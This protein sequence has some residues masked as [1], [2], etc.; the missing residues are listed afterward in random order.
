[1]RLLNGEFLRDFFVFHLRFQ[2]DDD[3]AREAFERH[4]AVVLHLR[5]QAGEGFLV[6]T[7]DGFL[8]FFGAENGGMYTEKN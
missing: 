6:G 4:V 2:R 7:H 1:M 8:L 3:F 5:L